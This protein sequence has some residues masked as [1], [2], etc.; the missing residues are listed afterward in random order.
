MHNTALMDIYV[1]HKKKKQLLQM[2]QQ[3]K[4]KAHTHTQYTTKFHVFGES[5]VIKSNCI[6]FR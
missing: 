3:Q 4:L 2:Q 1:L 5:K 6:V